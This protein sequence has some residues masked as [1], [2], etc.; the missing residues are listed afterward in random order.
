MAESLVLFE[1]VINSRWF[2]RTSIILFMNKIDLFAAKLPKV[3]LE[4]FFSDY[5]G[6]SAP[7]DVCRFVCDYVICLILIA[8]FHF[9]SFSWCLQV[10]QT[11]AK[12]QNIFSGDSRKP[13]EHVSTYTLSKYPGYSFHFHLTPSTFYH[14]WLKSKQLSSTKHFLF[15]SSR[16]PLF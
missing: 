15:S 3:P 11:L 2:L 12:R 14:V 7:W 5:T 9:F 16:A 4:K 8:E 13:T 6:K 1:S 10:A